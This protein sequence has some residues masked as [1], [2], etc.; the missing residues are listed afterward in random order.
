MANV[1]QG[2]SADDNLTGTSA[3]DY[4]RGGDGRDTIQGLEGNDTLQG[5]AGNDVLMGGVG[6]D[7]YLF[8]RGDGH[9]VVLAGIPDAPGQSD[10]LIFGPS[11]TMADVDVFMQDGGL[12]LV[13]KGGYDSVFVPDYFNAAE[14]DRVQIRF[15]GGGVLDALAINRALNPTDDNLIGTPASEVI[16]GGLGNDHLMGLEGNDLLYG[17]AGNDWMDGGAGADVYLFGYGDGHDTVMAM[18]PDSVGDQIVLASGINVSDVRLQA[19][20]PDLV[21]GLLGSNDSIRLMGYFNAAEPD[22]P[23][24]RF[25]SGAIWGGALVQLK[26]FGGD[27][28]ISGGPGNDFIEGGSGNDTIFGSDGNDTLYGDGGRDILIGGTGADTYLFGR[29]DGQDMVFLDYGVSG[30]QPDILQLG[31]GITMADVVWS[32]EGSDLL[33]NFKSGSERV[34]VANYMNAA[35]P[36]RL[37]VRFA[38]GASLDGAAIT[39]ALQLNDVFVGGSPTG[40]NTLIGGQGNDALIGT[41]G[42]DILYGGQGRD[43]MDG[44]QG[45]DVYLFG[46][47]DGQDMI[48]NSDPGAPGMPDRLRFASGINMADVDVYNDNGLLTLRLKGSDDMISIGNYFNMPP[49]VRVLIQFADGSFWDAQ[50]IDRKLNGAPDLLYGTALND[51][52]DGGAGNDVIAGMDGDDLLYGDTGNDTLFGGLGQDIYLFGRGDGQDVIQGSSAE[53][54]G[55]QVVFAGNVNVTDVDVRADGGDLLLRIQDSMAIVRVVGYFNSNVEDRPIIRFASGA[56]WDAGVVQSK[57]NNWSQGFYPKIG[58]SFVEGGMGNDQL[59]GSPGDDTLYGDGGR[60]FMDG[61]PGVDTYLFG[62]GDG[63]DTVYAG[64]IDNYG[65]SPKADRLLFGANISIADISVKQVSNT[66]LLVSVNGTGDSVLLTGYFN[67]AEPNRLLIQ[68]AD[69][70]SCD[71]LA[72]NRKLNATPDAIGP[73]PVGKTLD[74]GLGNDSIYG[75]QGDD[76]L[77]GDAGRDMLMG[78]PGVDT[79]WFGRGDGQDSIGDGR[80]GNERLADS[81]R[82]GYGINLADINASMLGSD[83]LLSLPGGTDSVQVLG[84]FNQADA[85][86]LRIQFSDGTILDGQ[87]V[88]RMITVTD[89]QLY[90]TESTDL[91]NGGLGND[92]LYGQSGDDV[93]YG[94]AGNDWLD[95][96]LGSDTYFFGKGDGVDSIMADGGAGSG[97]LDQLVLGSGITAADITVARDSMNGSDLQLIFNGSNDRI[98]LLGYFNSPWSSQFLMR[99]ADGMVWDYAA[100]DRKLNNYYPEDNFYGTE[101]DDAYDGGNGNDMIY[102][103]GGHDVLYGGAG[104]DLL[105]GGDGADTYLF[106]RGDGSDVIVAD[107]NTQP[108]GPT[109]VLQLGAGINVSDVSAS[110]QGSDLLLKVAGGLDQVRVQNYFMAH[111]LASMR[112]QFAD[113]FSWDGV[114]INR[115]IYATNDQL[116]GTADRDVLEGGLGNDTLLGWDDNDMLSGGSGRDLLDGGAGADTMFGGA[117][118]DHYIVD[119][120]NDV[121]VEQYD[122]NDPDSYDTVEASVSYVAPDNVEGIVLT[123]TN[124]INATGLNIAGSDLSGN[125]GNN[126]LKGSEGSDCFDGG[127]GSD[128]LE[129]GAG[130]DYYYLFDNA[131]T[132]VEQAGGGLDIVWAFGDGIKLP[133]NVERLFIK[134][135]SA[136]TAYGNEGSNYLTGDNHANTLYGNGGNDRLLSMGGDDV[137]YGGLGNDT[138]S[139]AG[140]N[141]TYHFQRGD[142]AD[143]ILDLDSTV[144]NKDT[145]VFDGAINANQVW[146]ARSGNDLV[147]SVIGTTDSVTVTNWFQSPEMARH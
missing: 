110:A 143:T 135:I 11:V 35:E 90:G 10:Q 115:Q 96:G 88:N 40:P 101:S 147:L 77:Y 41:N 26:L 16:D 124:N 18:G 58:D 27:V 89:D 102:G 30:A 31:A 104:N 24:L 45:S 132:V 23:V 9:D 86:H 93:L 97:D 56:A 50:A 117:G 130:S 123:G 61:G 6:V 8:D 53:L 139:G 128:T 2:S 28:N 84:Y 129:G 66:D 138:L 44:G 94:D 48:V 116:I 140:G 15:A 29:G 59:M 22:R 114:A 64:Y 112:I 105:D 51:V 78:G 95:G 43:F 87:S 36:D 131:S 19:D 57:L 12:L 122:A 33:L 47:G 69:G 119:N 100:I 49:Q 108:D 111:P 52:L 68:F 65:L 91:L 113:G 136:K 81:L 34:R 141:D 92:S 98:Q 120:V 63:Q 25:G 133:D 62:R 38:G 46:R 103:K 134:G 109:D 127:G 79:Y 3:A 145:L 144:G 42:D 107:T 20:G 146:L 39:R 118:D 73:Q 60:D 76:I 5:D 83:L 106:G 1:I 126:Y 142:G 32:I 13:L 14:P 125:S 67:Q 99:F 72:I 82:F 21:V 80:Y 55:D 17:D 71:A 4:I 75:T 74:G 137:L 37:T 85:D 70:S 7:T 54:S 121:L